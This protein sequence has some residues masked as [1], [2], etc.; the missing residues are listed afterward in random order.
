MLCACMVAVGIAAG[1][2]AGVGSFNVILS[3]IATGCAFTLLAALAF[4]FFEFAKLA[5]ARAD[6]PVSVVFGLLRQRAALIVLPTLLWPLMLAAYTT[7]KMA[8]PF[9]VGY[10]WDGFW[11]DA[12]RLIFGQDA[13]VLSIPLV[14]WAPV[15][16]WEW[17]YS[18]AWGVLLFIWFAAVPFFASKRRVGVMYTA[19]FAAWIIGGWLVAYATSAAGPVFAHLV[20]PTMAD[21]FLPMR[22]H[23]AAA[24]TP[25]GPIHRTQVALAT[26]LEKHVAVPAAGISAMPSMHIAMTTIYVLAAR[27][28][29]WIVPACTFWLI[30]FVGSAYFGY[31]YWIDGIVA[32]VIAVLCWKA[33]E[34]AFAPG[35]LPLPATLQRSGAP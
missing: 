11:A 10:S 5:R 9:I 16:L 34:L 24:L 15:R 23:L 33:A 26:V 4:A 7:A 3:Y 8:I 13:W 12:D 1:G 31:H 2:A 25:G 19:S 32:A 29:W 6:N 27:R 17:V 30:I 35:D 22:E 18:G 14:E 28:T 20:D 21:R